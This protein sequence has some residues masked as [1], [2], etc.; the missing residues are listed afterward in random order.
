MVGGREIGPILFNGGTL[1]VDIDPLDV[2]SVLILGGLRG[3]DVTEKSN[4][5]LLSASRAADVVCRSS[6]GELERGKE[7]SA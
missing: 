7:V 6:R 3:P 1:E 2:R 5:C 4:D